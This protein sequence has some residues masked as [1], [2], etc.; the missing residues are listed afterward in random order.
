[1]WGDDPQ[2]HQGES[3]PDDFVYASNTNDR[4]LKGQE[5]LDLVDD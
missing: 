1:L 5:I 4:W 2:P 3:L